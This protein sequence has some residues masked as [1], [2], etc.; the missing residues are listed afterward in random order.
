MNIER[1]IAERRPVWT[2]LE[3]A[4]RA[5]E[6]KDE[7]ASREQLQH[8]VELY[9]RAASDL[10]RVQSYTAN[11]EILGYLNQLVGTAYRFI[12]RAEHETRIADSL[13]ELVLREIPAAFRRHRAAV[14]LAALA[15][16][17]GVIV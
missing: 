6:A 14:A 4:L 8:I 2:E 7:R 13:R 15:M 16:L 1:F 12:Y 3:N 17:F 11:P 5:T 10:N 9:R